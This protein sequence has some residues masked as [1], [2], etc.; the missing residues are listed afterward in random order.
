MNILELCKHKYKTDPDYRRVFTQRVESI[1]AIQ[2]FAVKHRG[3]P[4]DKAN[5]LASDIVCSGMT[6]KE[7]VESI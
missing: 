2:E 3:W 1:V 6:V 7:F 4:K 5:Q